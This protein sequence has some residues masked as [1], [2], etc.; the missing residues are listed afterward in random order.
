MGANEY[1]LELEIQE[2][3]LTAPR[4]TPALVDAAIVEEDY[5]VFFG[6]LTVCVL[7]L[8]N[9][10]CVVG[11]AR[12]VSAENFDPELGRRVA[13]QKAREQIWELEG[14]LLRQRLS[15]GSA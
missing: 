6:T 14:Y 10:H 4:L 5:Q 12:P 11:T 3:G 13:R 8:R 15:E 7:R 9:G 2:R 1:T